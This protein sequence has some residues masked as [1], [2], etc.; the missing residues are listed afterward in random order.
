MDDKE[1][2][3][4]ERREVGERRGNAPPRHVT[5]DGLSNGARMLMERAVAA[6]ESAVDE[7][8]R[9]RR[10]I[11]GSLLAVGALLIAV[12][13]FRG[14]TNERIAVRPTEAAVLQMFAERDSAWIN[15][16]HDQQLTV[17]VLGE[18]QRAVLRRLDVTD[19]ELERIKDDHERILRPRGGP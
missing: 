12:G 1:W 13:E 3:D 2:P 11:V 14:S 16:W 17:E 7:A 9:T 5:V 4:V 10:W 8:R 18:R 19:D 6:G 15:L